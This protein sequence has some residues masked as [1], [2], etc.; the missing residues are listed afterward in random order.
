MVINIDAFR[1][2]FSDPEKENKANIIHRSHDRMTGAK[3]IEY[4]QETH[5]IVIIDEPQ[6][7]DT[8]ARSKQAVASLNPLCKLRY[9]ATHVDKYHMLY[10]LD[11]VDA[12]EQKLVKQI[13]VAGVDVV[14]G[15]NKAYIK[16]ISVDNKKSPITAKIEMDCRTKTGG[17]Q[18]KT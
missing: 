6:S 14:D 12:Y 8:T 13:E 2:S 4:I 15:H 18:R 11:S 3:P 7:V 10:K 5:P 9:S 1:K 17:V 16:L